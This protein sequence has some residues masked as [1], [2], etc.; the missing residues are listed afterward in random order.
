MK[1]FRLLQGLRFSLARMPILSGVAAN[2]YNQVV[3]AVIQLASL[4]F[5]LHFWGAERYGRWLMIAAIPAYFQMSDIGLSAVAMTKTC[6]AWARGDLDA[7]KVTFR[8]ALLGVTLFAL[9]GVILTALGCVFFSPADKEA[10]GALVLLIASALLSTYS[11][12]YDACFRIIDRYAYGTF[13]QS[14]IRL[15]E[16]AAGLAALAFGANFFGVALAMFVTRLI[17]QTAL[18]LYAH[19]LVPQLGISFAGAS[20]TEIRALLPLGFAYLGFTLGSA[21]GVQG[22]T[23]LVGNV[24]GAPALV[25]FSTYRTL[26]RTVTQLINVVGHS[27]WPRFSMLYGLGQTEVAERLRVRTEQALI[28]LSVLCLTGIALAGRPIIAFWGRGGL[29]YEPQVLLP[30]LAATALTAVYQVK[31]IAL[32]ATNRHIGVSLRFCIVS[33]VALVMARVLVPSLGIAAPIAAVVGIELAMVVVVN[34]AFSA[35]NEPPRASEP[36]ASR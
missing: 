1:T 24:L 23:L 6:I 11:S 33:A 27:I 35:A 29:S 13:L 12:L 10:G 32:I 8:S 5:F 4:P 34:I 2:S 7:A 18:T 16:W 25:V 21:L 17:C 31:L 9:A 19:R 15:G 30:L 36:L 26:S 22:L 3:T 28:A 14:S 20:F